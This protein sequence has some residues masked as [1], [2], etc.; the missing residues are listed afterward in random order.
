VALV[1]EP[2]VDA[3]RNR[4][5]RSSDFAP[6]AAQLVASLEKKMS[7]LEAAGAHH[8]EVVYELKKLLHD[9]KSELRLRT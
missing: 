2:D 6:A 5:R 9:I 3:R 8:A 7:E 4:S 1:R